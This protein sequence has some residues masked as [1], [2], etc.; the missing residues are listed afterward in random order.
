[1]IP[2]APS[3][4]GRAARLSPRQATLALAAVSLAAALLQAAVLARETPLLIRGDG[5]GYYAYLRSLFFDGDLDFRNE[6]GHFKVLLDSAGL[7]AATNR[8]LAFPPTATGGVFNPW[9]PGPA[10]LWLPFFLAGHLWALVSGAA[11]DGYSRP[12]QAACALGTCCYGFAGLL[13]TWRAC[14]TCAGAGASTLA[15]LTVWLASPLVAYHILVPWMPHALGF[16]AVA[17]FLALWLHVRAAPTSLGWGAL[18]LAAGLTFLQRYQDVLIVLVPAAGWLGDLLGYRGR[19]RLPA[20]LWR[21]ALPF[22]AGLTMAISPQLAAWQAIYGS[23][24]AF[25]HG[26]IGLSF[27]LRHLRLA[28]TLFAPATGLFSWSPALLAGACG[29]VS[30]AA[31]DA[32]LGWGLLALL[33][34]E[35]LLVAAMPP[36]FQGSTFGARYFVSLSPAFALGLAALIGRAGRGA[37]RALAAAAALL[38]AWNGILLAQWGLG[39]YD[40]LGID[41]TWREVLANVPALLRMLAARIF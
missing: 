26:E 23:P 39:M 6:Y 25:P 1:M 15:A 7:D 22:A 16:F 11:A 19:G 20:L 18:G 37:A 28:P 3:R 38:T 5:I 13:L 10:L 24:L 33:G 17:L 27:D 29:L 30:L 8:Y 12:Y 35:V 36:H 41:V 4:P 31:A 21:Q 40:R 14:R 9:P 32:A 34:A 2:A